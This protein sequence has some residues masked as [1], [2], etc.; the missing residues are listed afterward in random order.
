MGCVG[1]QG[2]LRHSRVW[3]LDAGRVGVEVELGGDGEAGRGARRAD[4]ADDCLEIHEWLSAPIDAD[5]GEQSVFDRVP[6]TGAR[7][8]MAHGDGDLQ[9]VGELLEAYLPQ[10]AAGAV[11][12]TTVCQDQERIRQRITS[13]TLLLPPQPDTLDGE[14]RGIV[15]GAHVHK[16]TIEG[17]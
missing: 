9:R 1:L 16:P 4:E 7:R 5:E 6:L 8:E 3:D 15:A 11:A 12:S 17:H 14:I 2:E 10:T 13:P